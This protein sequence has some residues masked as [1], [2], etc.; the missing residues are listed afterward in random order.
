VSSAAGWVTTSV[1]WLEGKY[2]HYLGSTTSS[3]PG[4]KRLAT[5]LA[6]MSY[7]KAEQGYAESKSL[8]VET[9]E[10]RHKRMLDQWGE[11]EH[12]AMADYLKKGGF[13]ARS[14]ELLGDPL[15]KDEADIDKADDLDYAAW[16]GQ[17]LTSAEPEGR[18]SG[19]ASATSAGAGLDDDE[20]LEM[21]VAHSSPQAGSW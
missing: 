3:T 15:A 10:Q 4:R 8:P 9:S 19:G 13:V 7:G 2:P 1:R 14:R 11:G 16:L 17:A 5:A 6:L 21:A 20:A 18:V 12:Q